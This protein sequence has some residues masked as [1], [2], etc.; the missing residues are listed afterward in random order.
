MMNLHGW[1][2]LVI[3]NIPI[4]PIVGYMFWDDL[5]DFW[6]S[7]KYL[8]IP[9]IISIFRG[10]YYDDWFE[11]YKV[12]LWWGICAL[13]VYLEGQIIMKYAPMYLP[14]FNSFPWFM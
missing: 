4:Y 6:L 5:A 9:D 2:A 8:F 1:I 3:F 13:L 10:E 7:A 14:F 12:F 11:E